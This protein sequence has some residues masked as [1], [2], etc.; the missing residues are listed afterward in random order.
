MRN[1]WFHCSFFFNN[2]DSCCDIL[3]FTIIINYRKR[4]NLFQWTADISPVWFP[5][6]R[7]PMGAC[8]LVAFLQKQNLLQLFAA[9]RCVFSF[10]AAPLPPHRCCLDTLPSLKWMG[11]VIWC[12]RSLI[13]WSFSIIVHSC[14]GIPFVVSNWLGSYSK[15]VECHVFMFFHEVSVFREYRIVSDRVWTELKSHHFL[16]V[17]SSAGVKP[18]ETLCGIYLPRFILTALHLSAYVWEE[19]RKPNAATW[20]TMAITFFAGSVWF[21]CLEHLLRQAWFSQW[22]FVFIWTFKHFFFHMIWSK[23]RTYTYNLVLV[24]LDFLFFFF[25]F[26]FKMKNTE[27]TWMLLGLFPQQQPNNPV[28]WTTLP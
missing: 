7:L 8:H 10:P 5:D 11:G 1:A 27:T 9:G 17:W 24:F 6:V 26:L 19:P 22:L 13:R 28:Q 21:G 23:N 25:F 3:L 4:L 2:C 18:V 14:K 12:E 16:L 15:W 20:A